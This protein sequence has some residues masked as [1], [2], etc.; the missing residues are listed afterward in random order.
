MAQDVGKKVPGPTGKT[1]EAVPGV[2]VA[3]FSWDT[4]IVQTK[5]LAMEKSLITIGKHGY[6]WK[7]YSNEASQGRKVL[8]LKYEDLYYEHATRVKAIAEFMGVDASDEVLSFIASETSL[9][10]NLE[11][12]QSIET[13]YPEAVFSGGGFLGETGLQVGHVNN[14]IK[15][16]PGKHIEAQPRM[17]AAI[18]SATSGALLA[19]RE[20]TEDMGY[21]L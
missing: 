16:M 19:L 2:R 7:K 4:P 14:N 3:E 8:F 9:Q 6:Y 17:M 18:K 20:M 10:K 1:L 12:V 11:V 15:G 13:H 21:E 5:S